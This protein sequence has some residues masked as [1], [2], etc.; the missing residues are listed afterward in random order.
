MLVNQFIWF[1]QTTHLRIVHT[2]KLQKRAFFMNMMKRH[3]WSKVLRGVTPGHRFTR[4]YVLSRL[5]VLTGPLAVLTGP[6]NA[7]LHLGVLKE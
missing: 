3:V 2:R 7:E 1:L 5:A 4:A 6:F